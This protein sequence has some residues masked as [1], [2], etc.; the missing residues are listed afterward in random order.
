VISLLP[1]KP[2]PASKATGHKRVTPSPSPSSSVPN[3]PPRKRVH[4][5]SESS[6]E[7]DQ[8]EV[9][10]MVIDNGPPPPKPPSLTKRATSR[11][12]RHKIRK[13]RWEKM[14]KRTE[15]LTTQ[16]GGEDPPEY[17]PEF[18]G[19]RKGRPLLWL[20]STIYRSLLL[21]TVNTIFE[22]L[23][24]NGQSSPHQT[25]F[26]Y[27]ALRKATTY[28]PS[29]A[30]K[31]TRTK[32]PMSARRELEAARINRQQKKQGRWGEFAAARREARDNRFMQ[33]VFGEVP[34]SSTQGMLSLLIFPEQGHNQR[35]S[36]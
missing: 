11:D 7:E 26:E 17:S 9:E 18:G 13:E 3:S 12:D 25:F 2:K 16:E 32:S 34:E 33:E 23:K 15:K 30:G 24:T 31:R 4:V 14:A 19:K 29:R 8:G 28:V 1:E 22:S 20:F 21:S 10:E 5:I 35:G 36:I 27:E 6:S